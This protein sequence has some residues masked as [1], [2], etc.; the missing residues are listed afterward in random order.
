MTHSCNQWPFDKGIKWEAPDK[1]D[2][3]SIRDACRLTTG[4][5]LI[6]KRPSIELTHTDAWQKRD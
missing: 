3:D 1:Y 5:S 2:T 4:P 6:L